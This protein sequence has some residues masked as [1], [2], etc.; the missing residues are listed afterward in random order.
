MNVGC[1]FGGSELFFFLLF[2]RR[3]GPSNIF[4]FTAVAAT[5]R[6]TCRGRIKKE[7]TREVEDEAGRREAEAGGGLCR[8]RLH[9]IC[10]RRG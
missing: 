2:R 3:H 6:E 9:R 1:F 5:Q 10:H 4:D 8:L 7:G